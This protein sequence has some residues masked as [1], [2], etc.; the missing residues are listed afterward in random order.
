MK[1]KAMN[2]SIR[3]TMK[4]KDNEQLGLD[5]NLDAAARVFSTTP[6]FPFRQLLYRLIL[7]PASTPIR[8]CAEVL[9]ARL[10]PIEPQVVLTHSAEYKENSAGHLRA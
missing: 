6:R 7:V 5:L 4:T 3:K 9:R 10:R 1:K 2:M 8:L